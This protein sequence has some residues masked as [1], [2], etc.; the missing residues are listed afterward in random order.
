MGDLKIG[1]VV[2]VP[3]WIVSFYLPRGIFGH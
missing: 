3:N 2:D 1:E